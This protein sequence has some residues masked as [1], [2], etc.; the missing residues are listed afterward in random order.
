VKELWLVGE[1]IDASPSPAM[2][3]AALGAMG[4]EPRY[5][6]HPTPCSE[7]DATLTRAEENCAGINVTAPYKMAAAQRYK[8][9]LDDDARD[10]GAVNTIVYAEGRATLA[11]NTDIE[12]VLT[13]WRRAA[14]D[15]EGRRIA[16]IGTGGAARAVAAAA[17]RAGASGLAIYGRDGDKA[18][19][20]A[21]T[22]GALGLEATVGA[23]HEVRLI[24]LAASDLDDPGAWIDRC[25]TPAAV[26]H[27]LRYG[28]KTFASRD[29]ALRRK[30]LFLDGSSML[31]AQ[32]ERALALFLGRTLSD[33]ARKAMSHALAMSLR[34]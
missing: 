17:Q 2:H 1:N 19:A 7:L 16:V 22:A 3:N 12:G 6:L 34:R 29:A 9:F 23:A 21:R 18:A 8:D 31:L 20:L 14:V 33:D 26:V 25:A 24:V 4:I 11:S 27:D 30:H 28:P 32:A 15:V 5:S 10:A 13:A